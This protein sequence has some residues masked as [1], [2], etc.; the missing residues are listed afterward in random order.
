MNEFLGID[1]NITGAVPFQGVVQPAGSNVLISDSFNMTN[2]FYGGTIG[3]RF[4]YTWCRWDVGA[5]VKVSFGAT[6]HS[7]V[8]DGSTTLAGA[9]TAPGGVLAQPSN[10][11]H[12]SSSDFSVVPEINL[13]VG[14]QV[15]RCIRVLVGYNFID[16]NRVLRPANQIDRSLD[17]TQAPTSAMFVPGAAGVAPRFPGVRTDFWAQGINVGMELK[18]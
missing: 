18:Y 6:C 7:A 16:W 3:A 12:Y 10:I 17:L 9:G 1:Q 5:T 4:G 15:T 11:G 2:R 13:T 8:I 14:Y